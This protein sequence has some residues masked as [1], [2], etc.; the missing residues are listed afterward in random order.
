MKL[1]IASKN[2]AKIREIKEILDANIDFKTYRDLPDWPDIAETGSTFEENAT[3]KAKALAEKYKMPALADDSGLIVEAL[4]QEPGVHSSRYAG[5]EATDAQNIEKLLDNL[6][7]I[8]NRRAYFITSAVFI[9]PG[10]L[11]VTAQGKVY[12]QII[13]QPQGNGG[14][15]YDPVFLPEGNDKT[16]GQMS[17]EEKNKLSHRSR[18][19][20]ELRVTL[21]GKGLL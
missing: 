5:E 16:F 4:G 7:G 10:K 15:G 19:L 1:I 20:H 8:T 12:G 17:P 3:L 9:D 6:R 14:F 13:E 21:T 2:P 11:I 18:A